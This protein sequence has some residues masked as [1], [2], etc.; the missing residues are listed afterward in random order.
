MLNILKKALLCYFCQFEVLSDFRRYQTSNGERTSAHN[1]EGAV[2]C[3]L[4]CSVFAAFPLTLNALV[5]G[6]CCL[7]AGFWWSVA[8]VNGSAR[9]NLKR[10]S[11]IKIDHVLFLKISVDVH[12]IK[13]DL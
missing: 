12:V 6:C 4:S 11:I 10:N 3:R 13:K 7:D 9:R 8:I 2:R 1:P 5:P